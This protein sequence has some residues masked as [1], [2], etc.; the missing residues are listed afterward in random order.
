[1]HLTLFPR[2][3]RLDGVDAPALREILSA[4]FH[5]TFDRYEGLFQ[6]LQGDAAYYKKPISL[7]HPLIF[8]YAHT[9]IFF[10][11]KLLLAGLIDQPINPRFEK[12]FA[13]GVDEMSWDDLDESHYDW[14][15]V[16]EVKYYREQVRAMVDRVIRTAPLDLPLNWDN[17]WW[18]IPM[19]IEHER[20]HLETTSVLIRQHR[21]DFVKPHVDWQPCRQAGPAPANQLVYVPS[22][23]VRLGKDH[24]FPYYG[25]DNE[26]GE[27]SAQVSSFRA[28]QYLVS[29]GE[30][31]EFVEAGGYA[32]AE[33]WEEE[34][35]GW[36]TFAEA[37]HP[38]F[39]VRDGEGWKLRLMLEEISLPW[40]WPVEVNYHEAKAFCNWKRLVTGLPVRLPT[41]DEWQR[42]HAQAG[43]AEVVEPVQAAANLQLDHAASS[44]P[45]NQFKHGE[46]FDVMG[47]VWQWTETPIYPFDGFKVHPIYDDFTTPTY[48]DRHNIIKGGSWISCGNEALSSS[49]YAFRRHFFQHAGFRYVISDGEQIA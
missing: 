6:V 44:C 20:I 46:F 38:T 3:P 4:Y 9:A 13:V 28:A 42:I 25:W 11:N 30:F 7:R 29:N 16:S 43:L 23:S 18:A 1:M 8:Y 41:E 24:A 34:G 12:M 47:N 19:G 17:P 45:V 14:P 27:H 26:Y 5:A 37:G 21:L 10:V 36:K 40:N 39:W 48:D 31:L 15:M 35:L 33:Y 49:R 32:N 2:T 22:G